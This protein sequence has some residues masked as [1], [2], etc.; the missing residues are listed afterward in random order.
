MR[1]ASRFFLR[2]AALPLGLAPMLALAQT[3]TGLCLQQVTCPNPAVTTTVSGRVYAPNGV[4]PLPGVLVYVPN[5]PVSAFAA[6]ASCRNGGTPPTSPLVQAIT[7]IDG[8]FTV[9]NMPAGANIPL[10]IQSGKWRRQIVIPNVAQCTNTALASNAARFPRNKTEG[11]IPQIA[12]VTGN[13]DAAECIFRKVGIDDA[14]VSASSGTGRIHLFTGA[15]SAGAQA[16]GS[17]SETALEASTATLGAYDMVMFACQAN[18][19]A[20]TPFAQQNLIGYANAGGRVMAT[21]YEYTWL[22]NV[23]PFSGTASWNVQQSP[24][25]ADQTAF[26]NQSTTDGLQ[27]AQWLQFVGATTTQGQIPLQLLRH[28]YDGVI[29]PSQSWISVNDANFGTMSVQYSFGTPV[30]TAPTKQCG[31][32]QYMDYH[33][34]STGNTTS[35]VFPAECSAGAMTPQEKLLE[36]LVFDLTKNLE[37]PLF[38]DGFE[39]P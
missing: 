3:C 29:P 33:V 28:D 9:A 16:S 1:H 38:A 7:G 19:F 12:V 4:D 30:G 13:G 26:I 5:A 35:L 37:P 18:Q 27:L 39:G 31:R 23:A 15:G 14:E 22:Y 25:P 11:D 24:I 10:V 2:A 8:S 17:V 36:Y 20:Q 34:E 6:G 32:V 21:H